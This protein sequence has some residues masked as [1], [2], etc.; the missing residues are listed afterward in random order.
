VSPLAKS[1]SRL[2]SPS[3]ALQVQDHRDRVLELVG[4]VLASLKFLGA[5]KWTRTSPLPRRR[6]RRC[7]DRTQHRGAMV[8]VLVAED[9]VELVTAAATAARFSR[10]TLG[11]SR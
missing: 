9:V 10:R 2:E 11:L 8:V 4:D 7:A 1:I 3:R 5:T 6:R